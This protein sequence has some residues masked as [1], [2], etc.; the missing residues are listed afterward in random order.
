MIEL[1]ILGVVVENAGDGIGRVGSARD[2]VFID[3]LL[4]VAMVSGN[5]HHTAELVDFLGEA[6]ELNVDSFHSRNRRFKFGEVADH[7]A[8]GVINADKLKLFHNF[9]NRIGDF[10][11]F[12]PRASIERLSVG[13][14]FELDFLRSFLV[15]V[16]IEIIS[17]MA[18]FDG[19]RDGE[20]G[21]FVTAEESIERVFDFNRR[22]KDI[23]RNM[24][25]SIIFGESGE[26]NVGEWILGVVG[27]SGIRKIGIGADAE[28]SVDGLSLSVV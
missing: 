4:G 5:N 3:E 25:V 22:D 26:E 10:G 8:A 12:H 6:G 16:A 21:D 2:T 19:F 17:D 23:F 13:K 7:V 14:D 18:K 11:R 1:G 28:F 24:A 9:E 20:L 27:M 15:A